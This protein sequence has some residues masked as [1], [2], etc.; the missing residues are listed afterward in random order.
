MPRIVSQ[1]GR[2]INIGDFAA[3]RGAI[4]ANA[5]AHAEVGSS[6]PSKSGLSTDLGKQSEN[7]GVDMSTHG[8][9]STKGAS[10]A[11]SKA[12]TEK[13]EYTGGHY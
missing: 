10:S 1:N 2:G 13:N 4:A 3:V 6:S 11:P 12:Q 8:K 5:A 9:N 7:Q